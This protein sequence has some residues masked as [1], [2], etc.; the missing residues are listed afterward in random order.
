M[1]RKKLLRKLQN[2]LD[3]AG[4]ADQKEI[5]KLHKIVKKLKHKQKSLQHSLEDAT[6][7]AEQRKLRQ[8][9]E[10]LKL[11]RKKGVALYRRLKGKDEVAN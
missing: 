4:D 9:I 2:L 3:N 11:Q 1:T 7:E 6:E 5:E 8:E 10:V